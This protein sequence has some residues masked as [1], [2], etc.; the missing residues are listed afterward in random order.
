MIEGNGQICTANALFSGKNYD[1]TH[2]FCRGLSLCERGHSVR[3]DNTQYVVFCFADP[4]HADAFREKFQ[5]ERFDPKDRS[6][7]KAWFLWRES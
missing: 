7:G 2:G 6:R 3:R 5:G 4:A 1:I